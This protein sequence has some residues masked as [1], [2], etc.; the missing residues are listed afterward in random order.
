MKNFSGGGG[1]KSSRESGE[2]TNLGGCASPLQSHAEWIALQRAMLLDSS[3]E[4]F[5][6]SVIGRSFPKDIPVGIKIIKKDM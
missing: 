1:K 4:N 6:I 5:G 3:R 2:M